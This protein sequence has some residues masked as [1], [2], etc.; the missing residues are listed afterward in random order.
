MRISQ[1]RQDKS[2]F[3]VSKEIKDYASDKS[4]R[5]KRKTPR[6]SDD[7][8]QYSVS[9]KS[10][11]IDLEDVSKKSRAR[12]TSITKVVSPATKSVR[13]MKS[14]KSHKSG[15]SQQR[16][17]VVKSSKNARSAVDQETVQTGSL[18]VENERLQEE[19]ERKDNELHI[20][21]QRVTHLN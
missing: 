21:E 14:Q 5:V 13:S 2:A 19:L 8:K 6:A 15:H 1:E 4:R 17:T 11:G 20:L 7:Y 9:D 18:V 16:S 10:I 12:N 3:N